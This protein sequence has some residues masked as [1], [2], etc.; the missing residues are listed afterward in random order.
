MF[1]VKG[2]L[3]GIVVVLAP[4]AVHA[5]T[6]PNFQTGQTLTAAQLNSAIEGKSD[7][8][9]PTIPP[10]TIIGM[11]AA[12]TLT[13][14]ELIPGVQSGGAVKMTAAQ[15]A[16]LAGPPSVTTF[17]ALG[18]SNGTTGN[19]H[20]DTAALQAAINAGGPIIFPCG[21]YRITGTLTASNTSLIYDF[22][23]NGQCSKIFNDASS[24][25]PTISANPVSLCANA[26]QPCL[27][28]NRLHFITPTHN[29]SGQSAISATNEQHVR[30][31]NNNFEPQ[32]IG[33]AL[34]TSYA[35]EIESNTF[36]SITDSAILI[37]SD[38]TSNG[39]LILGN[40]IFAS[41]V[42]DTTFAIIMG[43]PSTGPVTVCDN[44]MEGNYNGIL[45]ISIIGGVDC[46]NYIEGS[47]NI[48]Q[49]FVTSSAFVVSGNRFG[50]AIAED[51]SGL[52]NSLFSG[53]YINSSSVNYGPATNIY[54]GSNNPTPAPL[55]VATL[56]T[57]NS[58]AKGAKNIV[59]DATSPTYLGALTGSGAVVAPVVCNGSAWVSD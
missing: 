51:F 43:G 27:T 16:A 33:V 55:T 19:G 29:S 5:Q 14:S 6:S 46:S 2:L 7:Y 39:A 23:G 21:T 53:N 9:L 25:V 20:D 4:L 52:S 26:V 59:S 49:Y 13:G 3:V 37:A 12:S 8:P 10:S 34:T 57:C 28:V 18:N 44:D 11:P 36:T 1:S 22:E 58:A 35:P 47:V 40:R 41:G 50:T 56:P 31:T 24:A 54:D 32:F 38:G 30:I 17:G 45:W 48:D 42:T 15:I